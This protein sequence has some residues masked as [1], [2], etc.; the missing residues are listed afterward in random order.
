MVAAFVKFHTEMGNVV[1]QKR[2]YIKNPWNCIEVRKKGSEK[3]TVERLN[4]LKS[5]VD[6]DNID[7]NMSDRQNCVSELR[8]TNVNS[9]KN[10][11]NVC[12][13]VNVHWTKAVLLGALVI[14]VEKGK[15]S[16]PHLP[17]LRVKMCP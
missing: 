3:Y 10:V 2:D 17:S 5:F 4:R 15:I 8:T 13:I 16:S 7:I 9:R 12:T 1:Q 6:Q 14:H 11:F